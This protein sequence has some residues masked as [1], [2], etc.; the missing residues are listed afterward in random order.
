MGTVKFKYGTESDFN[1]VAIK[2]EDTIYFVYNASGMARIYKG[3]SL[4]GEHAVTFVDTVPDVSDAKP[5]MIY[6]VNPTSGYPTIYVMN[7]TGTKMEI[8]GGGSSIEFVRDEAEMLAFE[9]SDIRVGQ[10]V[11]REDTHTIWLYLGDTDNSSSAKVEHWSES[12]DTVWSNLLGYPKVYFKAYTREQFK[13]LTTYD[14]NTLYFVTDALQDPGC[15]YGT[16]YKGSTDITSVIRFVKS[17]S[18]PSVEDA[19]S[20][21]LY[22]D[23]D[24]L[25]LKTTVDN[26]VWKI[27]SP[28]YINDALKWDSEDSVSKL[29]TIS[30]IKQA[31]KNALKNIEFDANLG[32][33]SFKNYESEAKVE[34]TG[35]AHGVTY[36]NLKITIPM[37]GSATP[38][39]IDIPK[40]KFVKTGEYKASYVYKDVTYENVIVLSIDNQEDPVIIPA[41]SLVDIYTADNTSSKTITVTI[42]ADNKVSAI[43]NVSKEVN[44]V[45]EIKDDGLFVSTGNKVDKLTEG[46]TDEII[47]NN[48]DGNI[49]TSGFSILKDNDTG[50]QQMGNDDTKIPSAKLVDRAITEAVSWKAISVTE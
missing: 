8:I 14:D 34:L 45:V 32:E 47:V 9:A 33:V 48:G 23:V 44:N 26:I 24:T 12:S 42:S 30:V 39:V 46:N 19:I 16:V 5:G 10:Q 41:K 40:D 31:L 35:V 17:S 11:F 6:V 1:S 2:D 3:S 36:E 4:Y 50:S 25:E 28:G 20:N 38:L 15:T 49:K 27:I 22:L 37:Y 21:K 7:S 13:A 29:A 18:I 43:V